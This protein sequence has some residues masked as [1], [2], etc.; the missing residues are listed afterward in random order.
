M[1]LWIAILTAGL[2]LGPGSALAA[3]KQQGGVGPQRYTCTSEPE[4]VCECN[5]Y[6]DCD[7][8]KKDGVC[9]EGGIWMCTP[10]TFDCSCDWVQ[11]ARGPKGGLPKLERGKV[12]PA[13]ER[14]R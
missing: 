11:G 8:M 12:A 4:P 13:A 7:R 2:L 14:G 10:D 6:W 3:G 9:D 1:R 5:S